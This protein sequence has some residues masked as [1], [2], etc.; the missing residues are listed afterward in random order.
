MNLTAITFDLREKRTIGE[1]TIDDAH[2][3]LG[4]HAFACILVA[5]RALAHVVAVTVTDTR[6]GVYRLPSGA[7]RPRQ[8]TA[9]RIEGSAR[10]GHC[11]VPFV[12][13]VGKGLAEDLTQMVFWRGPDRSVVEL[14]ETGSQP[15][16][17]IIR[18]LMSP[19]PD[20]GLTLHQAVD[21]VQLC[22]QADRLAIDEGS[23]PFGTSPEWLLKGIGS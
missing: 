13:R 22:Y 10:C 23:Y 4:W 14:G 5:L 6:V 12:I 18:K 19:H 7:Q 9:A 20:L 8:F 17:R 11:C 21:V 15:H 1:R 3:D 16:E 2:W